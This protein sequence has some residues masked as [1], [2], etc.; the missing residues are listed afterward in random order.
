M[1]TRAKDRLPRLL[2]ALT[3]AVLAALSLASIATADSRSVERV[4]DPSS[5]G[6]EVVRADKPGYCEA[7]AGARDTKVELADVQEGEASGQVERASE[8]R[9]CERPLDPEVGEVEPR[10]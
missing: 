1:E 6:G 5:H 7:P 10:E 4:E 3:V 8:P 2:L 9:F